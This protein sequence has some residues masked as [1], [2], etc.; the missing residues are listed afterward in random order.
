[1]ATPNLQV[2]LGNFVDMEGNP[3]SNGYLLWE[4]SHDEQY[5][6]SNSQVVAG[7]KVR[8]TLDTSGNVPTN[9]PTLIYSNDVLAP[10]GSFYTVRA[11]KSDGTEAWKAPQY[12]Q[13]NASPN[14]LDLGTLIPLN[15]PGGLIAGGGSGGTVTSV[16]LS[17]PAEFSVA[18][19]PITTAGTFAVTKANESANTVWAGPTSGGAAAPTFRALVAA[20][21][22]SVPLPPIGTSFVY[23]D[24]SASPNP[25]VVAI[26][27]VQTV[28]NVATP[29]IAGAV[30]GEGTCITYENDP[31]ANPN[32]VCSW[33]A[34]LDVT[35]TNNIRS[36]LLSTRRYTFR[37]AM[38]APT[39]FRYW[40]G[41]YTGTATLNGGLFATD[42]PNTGYVA[43]RF[44]STTDTTWKAVTGTSNVAQ[45]VTN[46]GVAFTAAPSTVFQIVLN[47]TA[48]SI[49]FYINGTLA[50]TNT[51]NII[52]GNTPVAIFGTGD[53]K[54]VASL[55][56]ITFCYATIEYN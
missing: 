37:Q 19:S 20:D 38:A 15:P 46:T 48:T 34:G 16:A 14:P 44:S 21:I 10:T 43:F 2:K 29:H 41:V 35:I 25:V 8:M 27:G 52:G 28:S 5:S 22:P 23:C 56:T 7:L 3:L 49:G 6:V 4:L 18:G 45:T 55:P 24:G 36:T 9:P 13:L 50:A 40:I 39:S 47:S 12:F 30:S 26:E 42:T 53:N 17:M 11:F 32:T 1:M 54:N 51:T 33:R 31:N